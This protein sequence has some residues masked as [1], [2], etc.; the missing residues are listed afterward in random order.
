LRD[1]GSLSGY[2]VGRLPYRI[3]VVDIRVPAVVW[4]DELLL[5]G[6]HRSVISRHHRWCLRRV[7]SRPL[8]RPAAVHAVSVSVQ[9]AQLGLACGQVLHYPGFRS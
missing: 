7:N 9:I 1:R 5:G 3:T 4:K 2:L 6:K 8:A